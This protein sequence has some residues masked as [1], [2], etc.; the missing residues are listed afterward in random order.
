MRRPR[1]TIHNLASIDGRLTG[2]PVDLELY[3]GLAAQLP[4]QAVL[5]GSRTLLDGAAR[6][7]LDLTVEHGTG[8]AA[9]PAEG[10]GPP[11]DGDTRPWLAI[12]DG[13]GQVA[14]LSWLREQP[15]WR[16]LIVLGCA[17]TPPEHLERLRR[18]QVATI[19]TDGEHV[20]LATA[21]ATLAERYGVREVRVDAGGTLNGA[22][23]AAGLV[24]EVSLVVAPYV[25]GEQPTSVLLADLP[26]PNAAAFTLQAV[27][28]LAGDHLWVRYTA[29]DAPPARTGPRQ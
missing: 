5:T 21:L 13:R 24:D 19:V 20:D 9:D 22:L 12:V 3:Y 11:E 1:V 7:G 25:V 27:E 16:D 23:V 4:H 29:P 14:A 8:A 18:Q 15:Y 26:L 6:E 2:F 17:A 28:R 10:A